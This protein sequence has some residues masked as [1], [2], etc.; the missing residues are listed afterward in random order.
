MKIF[1]GRNE[2]YQERRPQ[3]QQ[4]SVPVQ[5]P[6][7][8]QPNFAPPQWQQPIR[9][10][11]PQNQFQQPHRQQNFNQ[12][13]QNSNP[14]EFRTQNQSNVWAPK[15]GQPKQPRPTPMSGI[16][17]TTTGGRQNFTPNYRAQPKFT[18]EE[19]YNIQCHGDEQEE[20]DNYNNY[21][22]P[23]Y[24]NFLQD[25]YENQPTEYEE[26]VNFREDPP[27]AAET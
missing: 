13:R 10:F 5:K 19:L 25:T 26:N 7:Y 17:E 1:F 3:R 11:Y 9:Q 4:V 15:P 8:Q 16:S 22:E 6:F 14:P 12:F 2:N 21:Y 20:N 24:D 27:E 18:V 23:E